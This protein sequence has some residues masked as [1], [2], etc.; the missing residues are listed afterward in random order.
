MA[1]KPVISNMTP[2]DSTKEKFIYFTYSGN[3]PVSNRLTIYDASTLNVVYDEVQVTPSFSHRIPP[4]TLKV[5]YLDPNGN[6]HKYAAVIVVTDA[7]GVE[8]SP[9]DKA[10]FWCLTDP[11]FAYSYPTADAN[12]DSPTVDFNVHYYQAEGEELYSYRH[13]LYDNTKNEVATSDMNYTLDNLTYS[14]KGLDNHTSYYIRTIGVT[15]NGISVDT[16]MLHVF[17]NYANTG[18]FALMNAES[19]DNATVTGYTNIISIDADESADDYIFLNSCVQLLD[20]KVTYQNNFKI[21]RDFTLQLKITRLWNNA[22]ICY[23]TNGTNY[24]EIS[25]YVFDDETVRYCMK[26]NNGFTDYVRYSD[27]LEVTNLDYVVITLRRI[28]NFFNFNAV[29]IES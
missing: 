3:L 28:G 8:S 1:V 18:S 11:L 27:A 10:Y 9:S 23:M 12:I 19:D 20:K 15:K 5:S 22:R 25:S 16:G 14:F 21:N 4:N 17:I 24:I 29:K 6:G 2:W 13:Y 7:N 26:A